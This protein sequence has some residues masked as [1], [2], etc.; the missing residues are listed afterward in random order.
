M[1][2]ENATF[3]YCSAEVS[4]TGGLSLALRPQCTNS[5]FRRYSSQQPM[6]KCVTNIGRCYS[7]KILGGEGYNI[8]KGTFK[9]G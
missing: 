5:Y 4:I 9:K 3:T 6:T 7:G 8:L 2:G 1:K